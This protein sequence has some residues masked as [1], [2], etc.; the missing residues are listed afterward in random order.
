MFPPLVR[1]TVRAPAMWYVGNDLFKNDDFL[2]M[3]AENAGIVVKRCGIG[4]GTAGR[5]R[6]GKGKCSVLN[7]LIQGSGMIEGKCGDD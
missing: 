6:L 7:L 5:P 1:R 3:T 2:L 4:E